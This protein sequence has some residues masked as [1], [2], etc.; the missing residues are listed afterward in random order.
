[1]GER[2]FQ[3]MKHLLAAMVQKLPATSPTAYPQSLTTLLHQDTFH[4][5]HF[6]VEP[7]LRG[8]VFS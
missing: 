5:G 2:L 1:M 7:T 6:S 3:L 4:D 8:H